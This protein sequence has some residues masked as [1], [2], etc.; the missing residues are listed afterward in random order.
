MIIH[1]VSLIQKTIYTSILLIFIFITPLVVIFKHPPT[2]IKFYLEYI[3]SFLFLISLILSFNTSI[4]AIQEYTF[5]KNIIN[6]FSKP[7]WIFALVF[8][9]VYLLENIFI[10][11]NTPATLIDILCILLS[12]ILVFNI[13]FITKLLSEPKHGINIQ[14]FILCILCVIDIFINFIHS[15]INR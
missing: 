5:F 2:S 14:W 1:T 11:Q 3:Y 6:L 4:N 8:Y 10:S 12:I 13:P 7:F 9:T 15:L